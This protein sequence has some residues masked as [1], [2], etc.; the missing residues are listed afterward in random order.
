MNRYNLSK[1]L[2]KVANL[3]EPAAFFADIGCDHAFL[4]IDLTLSGKVKKALCTDINEGPLKRADEHIKEYALSDRISTFQT[5]GLTGL[6][7]DF[8]AASICGMGGLMGI[9]IIFEA[10]DIFKNMNIFYLQLQSDHELLRLFLKDMGYF[11]DFEDMVFEDGKFYTVMKVIPKNVDEYSKR[12]IE[13]NSIKC[14]DDIPPVL[15]E[16]YFLLS[17]KDSV[18]YKYPFYEGMDKKVYEDFLEFLINKYKRIREFLPNDS[19]RTDII[20]KEIKIMDH[21]YKKILG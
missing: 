12:F 13:E 1:R 18:K 6:D 19:E 11:I 2:Q 7:R 15:R 17:V 8:D 3:V 4:A 20:D 9:K 5:D 14:F 16:Q 21:A 10:N